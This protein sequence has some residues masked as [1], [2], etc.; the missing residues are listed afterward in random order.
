MRESIAQ[1]TALVGD[2][3]PS[4]AQRRLLAVQRLDL[5]G[6]LFDMGRFAEAEH[7]SDMAAAALERLANGDHSKPLDGLLAVMAQSRRGAAH[8]FGRFH[9][10]LEF[11][12]LLAPVDHA[13]I[14]V[15][16]WSRHGAEHIEGAVRR[17]ARQRDRK[18]RMPCPPPTGTVHTS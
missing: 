10:G 5:A 12:E 9:S 15:E 17:T 16:Y 11:G 13:A 6:L 4:P 14:E 7:E 2:S 8:A 18:V 3:P 1:V